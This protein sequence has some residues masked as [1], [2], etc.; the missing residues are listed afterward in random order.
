MD[1]HE[2]WPINMESGP[3][4]LIFRLFLSGVGL[5]GAGLVG[6]VLGSILASGEA[7]GIALVWT[8][9]FHA[10]PA[11]FSLQAGRRVRIAAGAVRI[12]AGAPLLDVVPFP[13]SLAGEG[14]TL[15]REG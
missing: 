1:V 5:G 9:R 7:S 11:V 8:D 2:I 10:T 13:R 12:A 6:A 14:F 4:L 3:A 15:Q